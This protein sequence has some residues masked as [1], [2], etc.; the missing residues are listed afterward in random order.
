MNKERLIEVLNLQYPDYP[1]FDS[2]IKREEVEANGT[3]FIF[4]ESNKF[5]RGESGRSLMRKV[6]VQFVTRESKQINLETL[7]PEIQTA[8]LYFFTSDEELGK[9]QGTDNEALMIT[10]ECNVQVRK[11]FI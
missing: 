6:Y 9:I 2:D 8:G 3:F 7:I 1:V 11:C 4:R 5:F 10:M